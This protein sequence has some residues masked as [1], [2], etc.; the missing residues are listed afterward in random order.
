MGIYKATEW[1]C[2]RGWTCGDVSDLA[3]NSNAW[4]HGARILGLTPA[5][6]LRLLIEKYDVDIVYSKDYSYV[7]FFFKSQSKC[8]EY[9]LKLNRMAKKIGYEV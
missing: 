6:F 9:C 2:A 7:G 8:H 3:N 1:E 4:E 5:D